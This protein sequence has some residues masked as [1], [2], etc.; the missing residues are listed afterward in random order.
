ML[1]KRKPTIQFKAVMGA[2][3]VSPL[4]RIERACDVKPQWLLQQ[5]D[6]AA[7][8]KFANCPG[9]V[10]WMQAGYIIPAWTD[11]KI[12]ANK[13]GTVVILH[14]E[15]AGKAGAMNQ[16][17]IAGLPPIADSVKLAVT[18][19]TTPWAMFAAKG[20]SAHVLPALYHSPFLGDIFIYPGTVDYDNFTTVNFIFT[21]IRECEIEIPCG[22]PLLQVVPFK[23]ETI[24]G[25][26]GKATQ[27]EVDVH[28]YS[29]PTRVRAAYR[30]FF[31]QRK[32]YT[33]EDQ[34]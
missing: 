14:D 2:P 25:L 19:V 23:R 5:R 9:M 26:T 32:V 13:A 12:K 28:K 18:K 17:L 22:T 34:Q 6:N 7:K 31:H 10:D 16:N 1:F 3:N 27:R 21:A 33:L 29:F 8:D 15:Y 4:S 30:K 20:Y 11:I 24:H